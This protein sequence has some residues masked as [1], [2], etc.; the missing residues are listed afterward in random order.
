MHFLLPSQQ[1]ALEQPA[2]LAPEAP[3]VAAYG[4]FPDLGQPLEPALSEDPEL[5]PAWQVEA[6]EFTVMV[7]EAVATLPEEYR[8]PVDLGLEEERPGQPY[9]LGLYE[10]VPETKR[11]ANPALVL[12]HRITLFRQPLM[13]VSA[14]RGDLREQV[15]RTVLHEHGHLL[16]MS[17]QRLHELGY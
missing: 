7:E 2:V 17:D 5:A 3:R 1:A 13:R 15:W 10:G 16:G 12:P 8:R 6:D 11:P 14:T 4:L 9:L